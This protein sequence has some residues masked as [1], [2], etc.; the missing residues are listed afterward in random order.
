MKLKMVDRVN[1]TIRTKE[2][3][4]AYKKFKFKPGNY[5]VA[6]N[7]QIWPLPEE[8][9]KFCNKFRIPF[10]YKPHS[11]VRNLPSV[12][13]IAR[14]EDDGKCVI[15]PDEVLL[16]PVRIDMTASLDRINKNIARLYKKFGIHNKE[17][18]SRDSGPDRLSIWEV[19]N[20]VRDVNEDVSKVIEAIWTRDPK[21]RHKKIPD[22][23]RKRI[24]RANAKA[25]RLT[26]E[27]V[28]LFSKG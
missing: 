13:P 2:Y 23:Y 24:E 28:R 25:I 17:E 12:I 1:A 19:Q 16:L 18:R 22:Y 27:V 4:R 10:P 20:M 6:V 21:N 11:V 15:G 26:E 7:D 9:L 5:A 14:L 8:A 3:D